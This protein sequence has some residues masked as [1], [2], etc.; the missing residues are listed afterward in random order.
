MSQ[1]P[2]QIKITS[3][4]EKMEAKCKTLWMKCT[5]YYYEAQRMEQENQFMKHLGEAPGRLIRFLIIHKDEDGEGINQIY[6]FTHEQIANEIGPGMNARK[7]KEA[8]DYLFEKNFLR[9]GVNADG[10]LSYSIV[11]NSIFDLNPD[12]PRPNLPEEDE[13]PQPESPEL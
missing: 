10:E 12:A 8:Y 3:Y 13:Q 2:E 9:Q 1:E 7:V 4:M 11:W 5:Q 6:E